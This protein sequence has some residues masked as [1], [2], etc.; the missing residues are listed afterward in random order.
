MANYINGLPD[1]AKIL[2][3]DAVAYPIVA[4]TSNVK[5]L[6]LPYQENF[7][8]VIETPWNYGSYYILVANSKNPV[9]AYSMLNPRYAPILNQA[10][11][12]NLQKVYETEHWALYRL[13]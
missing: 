8:S 4:F 1:D 9:N 3:D 13:L 10:N 2:V 6:T 11:N 5:N 7:I 12:S